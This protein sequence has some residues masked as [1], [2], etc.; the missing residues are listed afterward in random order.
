MSQI[1]DVFLCHTSEEKPG[2]VRPLVA[3]FDAASISNW[4]DEAEIRWGDSITEKVNKGL[5]ISRF[6]IVVLSKTF[7]FKKW[8][9]RE[10][11]A[12]LNLEAASGE[13]R[14]LPLIVGTKDEEREI[15]AAY[16]LLN[17]KS[18]LRW[19]ADTAVV[20]D[21]LRAR[22]SSPIART[23]EETRVAQQEP[24]RKIPMPKAKKSFT[25]RDK[26]KFLHDGFDT[27]RNYFE[28]G[29]RELTAAVSQMEA[30][31]AQIH[32]Y[33]FVCSFYAL[34]QL[35][36]RCK[37]WIGGPLSAESISYFEGRDVNY[38]SDTSC[39][40]WLSIE[41]TSEGIGFKPSS[42]WLG[43]T[44]YQNAQVLSPEQGAEY[45]WRRATGKLKGA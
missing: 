30:D 38:D 18:F 33:K 4:Y 36:N 34:G 3:A 8:P 29:A 37:I 6:V 15:L 7:I 22:L 35:A 45:L 41:I 44:Q 12:A 9:Q 27:I 14:V 19:E 11:N 25:Q 5:A 28:R 13:V 17:D 40:D 39:N 21:A 42:M 32:R 2:V 31:M 26:D 20:V 10:L 16:P 1:R 43:I 23:A 24:Q